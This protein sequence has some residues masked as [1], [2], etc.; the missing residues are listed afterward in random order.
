M[1]TVSIK[2][3]G[4]LTRHYKSVN[5]QKTEWATIESP[6]TV[7]D[8]LD[9]YGISEKEAHIIVVN[10]YKAQL[11]TILHQGDDVW[12]LPLAHGG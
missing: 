4:R 7:S 6:A 12:V 2:L 9:T 8:L 11:N 5:K 3:S 10:R 1:I